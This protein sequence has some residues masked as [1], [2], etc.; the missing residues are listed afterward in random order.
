[1]NLVTRRPGNLQRLVLVFSTIIISSQYRFSCGGI[2][3]SLLPFSCFQIIIKIK[4]KMAANTNISPTALDL[5]IKAAKND[6]SVTTFSRSFA[7]DPTKVTTVTKLFR[8]TEHPNVRGY[9][10]CSNPDLCM[11]FL[12]VMAGWIY[13]FTRPCVA[14]NAGQ[15]TIYVG[16]LSDLLV[17]C[18]PAEMQGSGFNGWFTSLVPK[19]DVDTFHLPYFTEPPDTLDGPPS[20]AGLADGDAGSVARLNYGPDAAE[21]ELMIAALPIVIPLP[22]GVPFPTDPWEATVPNP[23][24]TQHYAF[25]EV[26]RQAQAYILNNNAGMSVTMGGPLFDLTGIA[27]GQVPNCTIEPR[28]DLTLQM[29][30]PT[31]PHFTPVKVASREAANAAYIRIGNTLP[32]ETTAAGVA[33]MFSHQQPGTNLHHPA[34]ESPSGGNFEKLVEALTNNSRTPEVKEKAKTQE[35]VL[36]RFSLAFAEVAEVSKERIVIPA[37][38]RPKFIEFV[39]TSNPDAAKI[40]WNDLLAS[41]TQQATNSNTRL[42][43][44]ATLQAGDL[45]DGAFVAAVK[46]FRFLKRSLTTASAMND[47]K[48]QISVLAFGDPL[49]DGKAY[50]DRLVQEDLFDCQ[51][52]VGEE[53]TKM[54]R[55]S[56]ELYIG[57][58]L[59]TIDNFKTLIYNMRLFGL[60]ICE[61]FEQSEFWKPIKAY[62]HYLQKPV[63]REWANFLS[64]KYKHA[65]LAMAVELQTILK[66]YFC[67]GDVLEYRDAVAAGVPIDPDVYL[68]GS[69]VA[70]ESVKRLCNDINGMRIKNYEEIPDIAHLL[71]HLGITDTRK[72]PAAQQ[73]HQHPQPGA[74][75]ARPE[76]G[77]NYNVNDMDKRGRG[78]NNKP[79]QRGDDREAEKA[80]G[81]LVWSGKG[82]PPKHCPVLVKTKTMKNKE[83][84]CLWHSM[85]GMFCGRGKDVCRQGHIKSFGTLAPEEQKKMEAF[86]NETPGLDFV[87][88]QGPKGT[89]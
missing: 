9:T 27:E 54:A 72:M 45:G 89:V 86:V 80:V 84:I 40:L 18:H 61:K 11:Q 87:S 79:E 10:L 56:T 21:K 29:I 73:H 25:V 34:G 63:G 5:L 4:K 20:A 8:R 60:A 57:G 37:T 36:Q 67:L 31:S 42:D 47:A 16:N 75:N 64:I 74:Q 32:V 69:I 19:A 26:W 62:E 52:A 12:L 71:P 38:L 83:R 68:E 2:C 24:A 7:A 49:K 81:F 3:F 15:D 48:T 41:I 33:G 1:M 65:A 39:N 78:G 55:K 30:P 28:G 46:K 14:T 17:D 50:R 66:F 13:P 44:G 43:G 23:E 22:A 82:I 53:K 51:A 70:K 88:G 6:N 77:G 59:F 85:Q 35:A 76:N 58:A